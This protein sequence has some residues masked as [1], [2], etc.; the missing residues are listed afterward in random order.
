MCMNIF[1]T[2]FVYCSDTKLP[3]AHYGLNP[4]LDTPNESKREVYNITPL[5]VSSVLQ[6]EPK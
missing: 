4:F 2:V 5:P 3:S 1:I 6:V